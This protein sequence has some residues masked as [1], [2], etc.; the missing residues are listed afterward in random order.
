ME[1]IEFEINQLIWDAIFPVGSIRKFTNDID[2]NVLYG[3]TWQKLEG[4][5]LFA[6]DDS[7]PLGSTG[8]EASHILSNEELPEMVIIRQNCQAGY[9]S[10]DWSGPHNGWG[11]YQNNSRGYEVGKPHNNMPPYRA[12]NVWERIA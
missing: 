4:V 8:G 10:L 1:N 3:G 2:P 5:F 11:N 7:H 12:V 6:S 9:G